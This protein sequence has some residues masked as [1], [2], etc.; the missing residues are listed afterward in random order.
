MIKRKLMRRVP[1]LF[2]RLF[3]RKMHIPPTLKSQL[4]NLI[5]QELKTSSFSGIRVLFT[6]TSGTGKTLAASYLATNLSIPLYR[7]DLASIISKY[8]GETEKNLKKV[9]D[10]A[11]NKDWILFLDEA[12]ALFGKRTDVSD[13]HDRFA[14]QETDFL[15]QRLENHEGLVI[16]ASNLKESLDEAFTRKL[17]ITTTIKTTEEEE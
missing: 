11:E 8:I 7:I 16:L 6:G 4:D 1:S 5:N 12:D 17:K 2:Q 15:L 3:R 9:F 14:N 10:K 13:A